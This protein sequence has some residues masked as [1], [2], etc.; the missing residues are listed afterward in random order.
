[1]EVAARD[2]IFDKEVLVLERAKAALKEEGSSLEE[3]MAEFATLARHYEKLLR[4]ATKLTRLG[5]GYQRK[6]LLAYEEIDRQKKELAALD[7]EKNEFLGIVAHDLKNP[8]NI[9]GG[10]IE[11]VLEEE[12]MEAAERAEYL[13]KALIAAR[14]MLELIKNLLDVNAIERGQ[15]ACEPGPCDLAA[16]ASQVVDSYRNGAAAKD[17][18]IH[19]APPEERIVA[20]ADG[21]ILLQV[22][23]NLV[24][25][26]VKY[27][28]RGKSIWVATTTNGD[29]NVRFEVKDEG[30]GLSQEDQKKLFG[31]FA[32]LSARPTGGEHS[33]GLGLSIVKK[34]VEAMHGRV[35]C[36]SR[37]GEGTTFFLELPASV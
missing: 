37:L 36:E 2:D 7:N 10:Y 22:C 24:S 25:N 17:Q 3:R 29:G 19:F 33:T 21:G 6:M 15:L 5:D 26:A 8:L 1:M 12:D 34:M 16:I 27:S 30:P 11:M 20:H 14:R 9:I 31:K 4:Q 18:T 23:D 35:W 28:P 32:R 13:G